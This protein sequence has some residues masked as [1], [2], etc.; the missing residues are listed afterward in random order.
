VPDESD[1]TE[2]P[3]TLERPDIVDVMEGTTIRRHLRENGGKK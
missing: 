1:M 2:T 3:E